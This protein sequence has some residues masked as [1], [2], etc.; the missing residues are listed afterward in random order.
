MAAWEALGHTA[1]AVREQ[2]GLKTAAQPTFSVTF[3]L[4]LQPVGWSLPHSQWIFP[5][6][7]N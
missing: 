2:G 6:L 7:L 4:E 5:P 3:G 1:S